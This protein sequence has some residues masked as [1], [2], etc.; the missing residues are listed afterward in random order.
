MKSRQQG[1]TQATAAVKASLSERSGR[2][3]EKG[4]KASS[5]E[6]RHWRTRPDPLAAVWEAELVPLLEQAPDLT[7]LTLWEYLDEKYPSAYDEPVLR[8]LQQRV[9]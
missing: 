3:I 7:G 4:E 8:T 1:S 5:P 6:P 2:R 9:K